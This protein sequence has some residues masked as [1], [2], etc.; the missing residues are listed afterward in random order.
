MAGGNENGLGLTWDGVLVEADSAVARQHRFGAA[1]EPVAVPENWRHAG[2]FKSV[3]FSRTGCAAGLL[4]SGFKERLDV[5]RLQSLCGG[6]FHF[7]AHRADYRGVKALPRQLVAGDEVVDV[8][9]IDRTVHRPEQALPHCCPVTV[10]DGFHEEFPQGPRLEQFA[11]HI[12][13]LAA[14]GF[15][16]GFQFFEQALVNRAFAG[17]RRYQVPQ[18]AD[19]GLADSVDA[20]ETLLKPVGIPR[21]VVIDH[22]IRAA[23]EVHA[24][25]GRIVGQQEPDRRIV[26]ECGDD[27]AP[28]VA[29]DTAVDHRDAFRLAG[30]VA[31]SA[32]E[33]FEG[34]PGFGE[35]NDLAPDVF[36]GVVDQRVVENAVELPPLCVLARMA[37]LSRHALKP[38][39][40]GDFSLELGD[41]LRRGGPVEQ[42]FLAG[43]DFFAGGLVEIILVENGA[44]IRFNFRGAGTIALV[45]QFFLFQPA[46]EP[47]ESALEGFMDRG[48]RGSQAALQDLK[49]EADIVAPARTVLRQPLGAVHL[50]A[51]IQRDRLVEPG[52]PGR[53]FVGNSI[54]AAFG[55]ERAAV[56]AV[57]FLLGQPAHHVRRIDL[58]HAFA[59]PALEA[60]GVEQTHEK[61]EILFLAIVRRRG[62]QQE[63]AGEAPGERAELE[64]LGVFDLL[65]EKTRRHAVRLVADDKVPFRGGLEFRLEFI[66]AR[67]HVEPGDQQRLFREWV[68]GDRRFDL[69]PAHDREGEIEL[70][71]EFVLPLF[72][73]ASRRDDEAALQTAPDQQFLDQQPGHNG[74]ARSRVIGEQEPQ[75]LLFQHRAINRGQLVRQRFDTRGVDRNIRIE[76]MGK[77]NA[78]GFG[79]EPE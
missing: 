22:E 19:F 74:F 45:A 66:V 50:F 28:P 33:I 68:A 69:F 14:E 54:G 6:T 65:A 67:K 35:D 56:E 58:V 9:H 17:F 5:V 29:G 55:K 2:Q 70:V 37:K 27:C 38:L 42:L 10:A 40:F 77:A 61:L 59:E 78:E 52:F 15:P 53:Q 21:Q 3:L 11:E 26:V 71:V 63:V 32:G 41:G 60:V 18:V 73:Q 79:S 16:R 43:F 44:E 72:D 23:L 76:Q 47:G 36:G 8:L 48:W 75:R 64:A 20:A 12:V 62:H 30:A 25:A 46:F 49:G 51:D 34:V 39:E 57:E 13:D 1:D 7:L 31:D 24:F 4:E